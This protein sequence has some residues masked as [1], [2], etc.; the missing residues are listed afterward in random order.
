MADAQ[1]IPSD[2]EAIARRKA[3]KDEEESFAPDD[4]QARKADLTQALS[5][6]QRRWYS[7]DLE[8]LSR[9]MTL[10]QAREGKLR[11]TTIKKDAGDDLDPQITL[12]LAQIASEQQQ[13][14]N[15]IRIYRG[16]LSRLPKE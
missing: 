14:E 10:K 2:P 5:G 13:L 7:L 16:E 12:R 9:E 15:E 1:I 11:A 4:M 8:R 6:A 3:A